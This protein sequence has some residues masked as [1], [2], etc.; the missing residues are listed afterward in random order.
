MPCL[1]VFDRCGKKERTNE[2]NSPTGKEGEDK[3]K[4][5]RVA[6]G[7]T[8]IPPLLIFVVPDK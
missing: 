2:I 6:Q 8:V 1:N 7:S 5:F 3:I 4:E